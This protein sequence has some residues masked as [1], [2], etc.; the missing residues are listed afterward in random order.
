MKLKSRKQKAESRKQK[1]LPGDAF[2]PCASRTTNEGHLLHPSSFILPPSPFPR[3]AYTLVEMLIVIGV[4]I[5][6]A[7]MIFPITGAIKRTQIRTR[8]RGELV[9]VETA[10][11][12]YKSKLGY[13]PPDNPPPTATVNPANYAVNQLYYELLGTTNTKVGGVLYYQTLDGSAQMRTSDFGSVFQPNVTGFANCSAGGGDEAAIATVFL[14]GLKPGQFLAITNGSGSTTPV[15]TVLGASL[16]GPLMLQDANLGKLNPWR[17]NSSNPIK[18]PKSFDLW[19][20]VKVGDKT[21]RICN[22][23]DQPLIVAAPYP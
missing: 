17:Y 22:W 6:L 21:N 19:I 3:R 1:A 2:T 12:D 15:C 8:A 16:D 9:Q 18:N 14:R 10:I 23:S 11:E 13:Y 20:D 4:M 7:S 5:M